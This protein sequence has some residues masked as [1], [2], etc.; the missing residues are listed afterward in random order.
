[1]EDEYKKNIAGG[2]IAVISIGINFVIWP[3]EVSFQIP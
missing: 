2:Y 1:V 3:E